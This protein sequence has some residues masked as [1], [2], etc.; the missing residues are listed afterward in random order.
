[1]NDAFDTGEHDRGGTEEVIA[2]DSAF[3]A[4]LSFLPLSSIWSTGQWL[5]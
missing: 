1:M 3:L 5:T 4:A 2:A